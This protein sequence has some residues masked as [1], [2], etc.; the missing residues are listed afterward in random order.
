MQRNDISKQP[1]HEKNCLASLTIKVS[2]TV[3]GN[4]HTHVLLVEIKIVKIFWKIFWQHGSG[5]SVAIKSI[6]LV[7]K[8][9]VCQPLSCINHFLGMSLSFFFEKSVD[10]NNTYITN[11]LRGLN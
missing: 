8:Y 5:S 9:C 3:Q 11:L 4:R 1:T 6:S 10:I 7:L 2:S